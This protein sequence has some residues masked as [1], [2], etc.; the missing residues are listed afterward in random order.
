MNYISKK[1]I[2]RKVHE[3]DNAFSSEIEDLGSSYQ[4]CDKRTEYPKL[5]AHEFTL[6]S[7]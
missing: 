2:F 1:Q 3:R 5:S 6:L 7:L 4:R